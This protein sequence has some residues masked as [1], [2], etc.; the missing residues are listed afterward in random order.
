MFLFSDGFDHYVEK[1]TAASQIQT[2]L[3]HA[4][5]IVRNATNNTFQIGDGMDEGSRGLKLTIT[6]GHAAPPSLSYTVKSEADV[7][8]FG[9]AFRGTQSRLRIARIDNVAD[10]DWDVET[11]KMKIGNTLGANVIIMNAWWYIEVEIDKTAGK[12][13][14]YANDTFQIETELPIGL[15]NE[16]TITW[17]MTSTAGANGVIELDD[18]YVVDSSPGQNTGRLGPVAV[19]TRVPTSTEEAEWEIVNG[20]LLTHHQIAAQL[21][22]GRSNA[23]YLQSNVLGKRDIFTSNVV[24]P[25]DNEVYAVS[26]VAY[27]RKGDLDDRAVGLVVSTDSGELEIAKPLTEGFAFHQAVFEQAPGQLPWNQNRVEVSK[28]GIVAR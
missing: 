22:A 19:I 8:V 6:Q 3:S 20:S 17:G 13:R 16:H 27:A 11:G 7:V 5:Y 2:Y 25:N 28:F 21:D 23:P 14:V 18:F 15:G 24:L 10:I 26:V 4:G 9:F 1:G 12:M